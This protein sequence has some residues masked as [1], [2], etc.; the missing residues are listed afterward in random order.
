LTFGVGPNSEDY[1]SQCKNSEVPRK[2]LEENEP[3][4]HAW[5]H[6]T[7][8]MSWANTTGATLSLTRQNDLLSYVV[9]ICYHIWN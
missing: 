9:C 3:K 7:T 1:L 2:Q 4:P 5:L 8:Q 6:D